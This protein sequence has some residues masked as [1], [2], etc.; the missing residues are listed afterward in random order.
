MKPGQ[1]T[2][3]E[4]LEWATAIVRREQFARTYGVI[5]IHLQAGRIERVK[6]ETT[7]LPELNPSAALHRVESVALKR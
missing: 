1:K 7:E 4:L 3:D 2:D 5:A 6:I